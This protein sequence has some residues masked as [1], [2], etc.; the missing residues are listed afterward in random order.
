MENFMHSSL[1]KQQLKDLGWRRKFSLALV[2]CFWV[3]MFGL[4]APA[5]AGR[6][7]PSQ[8]IAQSSSQSSSQSS[9]QSSQANKAIALRYAQEGWG[10]QSNWE[11]VWDEL[12][13]SDVVLH[14]NSFPEPI[15]GLDA[16]KEFSK[17]LFEG[18]PAIKNTIEDVV[19]EGD[20]VIIRSTLEGKQTGPFLGM[21]ATDKR[22]KMNDFTLYKIR[23]GKISEMWYETNLLSLM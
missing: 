15:V 4:S 8:A 2:I 13:A 11:A 6:L 12:V 9:P 22:V 5:M 7:V 23:D 21:A 16:N 1:Q 3:V 19:A 18:F 17:G 14:F 10:T 20:L